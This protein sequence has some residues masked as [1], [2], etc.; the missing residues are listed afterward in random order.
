M[1]A[2]FSRNRR[3]LNDC[4]GL[5]VSSTGKQELWK[6]SDDNVEPDL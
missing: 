6:T 1:F 3:L 4:T 5:A 2:A